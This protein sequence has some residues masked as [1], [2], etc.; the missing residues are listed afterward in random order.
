MNGN[1]PSAGYMDLVRSSLGAPPGPTAPPAPPQPSPLER[2]ILNYAKPGTTAIGALEAGGAVPPT[3]SPPL[4]PFGPGRELAPPPPPPD[5]SPA[6]P[7]PPPPSP[8]GPPPG[9][10]GGFPLAR[11][12]GGGVVNVPER[13]TE[14]RGPTLRAAQVDRNAAIQGAIDA[15]NERSQATAAQDFAIALQ[16]QRRAQTYEDAANYSAAERSEELAQRQADFDESVKA[17]SQ[18]QRAD[19][20]AFA[21]K[22]PL[23]Q[24]GMIVSLTLGGFIQGKRGGTNPGLDMMNAFA[25]R[26]LKAQELNYQM[27]K[28]TAQEKQ[29]AFAMAMQKYGNVD[30]ARS[31]AR[32]AMMDSFQTELAQ[33][34]AR[35]R[36][37]DAA[38]RAQMLT[39]ALQDEKMAQIQQGIQFVPGRQVA[40]GPTWVDEHGITY[41]EKGAQE[42]AKE[43]RG[44]EHEMRKGAQGIAGKLL[45]EG[46]KAEVSQGKDSRQQRVR[47]HT[48]EIVRA[49][50]DTEAG[51]LRDISAGVQQAQS[52]VEEARKIREGKAW[53]VPGTKEH[54]RLQTIQSELTLAFKDRGGLGALSGPDMGLANSATGDITSIRPGTD[55]KLK[56]F[57]E[58]TNKA[59]RSR[60]GTY[61]DATPSARG[62]MPASLVIHGQK[63]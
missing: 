44:Q 25:D 6:G 38:N 41:N 28:G 24:I 59:L 11:I 1:G 19:G 7:P 32:A 17:L 2:A 9:H 34:S 42:V 31:A 55:E 56:A 61:A 35:W 45:E 4:V 22:N 54:A 18:M 48:G 27:A 3:A 15:V 51:K 29:T 60:V 23:Q 52:L 36:G 57:S 62:E 37:T 26:E 10:G 5:P 53:V 20:N 8:G 63:K 14:M 30:A 49:P 40:T 58:H 13:E 50:S 33:Q 16:Q 46:A 21:G 47:L 43:L 39:A 12:G